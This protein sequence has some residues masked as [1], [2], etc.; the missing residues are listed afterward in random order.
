M[1]TS[2]AAN[3]LHVN[4]VFMTFSLGLGGLSFQQPH[5]DMPISPP[6]VLLRVWSSPILF[7]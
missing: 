4:P 3:L 6:F 7:Q 2:D 1:T 5:N